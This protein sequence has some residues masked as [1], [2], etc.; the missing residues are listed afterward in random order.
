MQKAVTFL[1]F[2][3]RAATTHYYIYI[4]AGRVSRADRVS[5]TQ[6]NIETA[7]SRFYVPKRAE[8]IYVTFSL[9]SARWVYWNTPSYSSSE[10]T[11]SSSSPSLLSTEAATSM[12]PAVANRNSS[13]F[14]VIYAFFFISVSLMLKSFLVKSLHH[15][16]LA[17]D[18]VH[19]TLLRVHDALSVDVVDALTFLSS[20]LDGTDAGNDLVVEHH[21]RSGSIGRQ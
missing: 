12:L 1:T 5:R 7:P 2:T 10:M 14:G 16:F 4:R 13:I 15:D 20:H 9:Q 17:A 18:D 6:R 21:G 19:A 11:S 3:A 8:G